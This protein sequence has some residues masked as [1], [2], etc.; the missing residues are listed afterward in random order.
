M[1]RTFLVQ[2]YYVKSTGKAQYEVVFED[3]GFENL[4]LLDG[5]SMLSMVRDTKI[6]LVL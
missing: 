4:S 1:R 6:N 5:K 2:D 3:T